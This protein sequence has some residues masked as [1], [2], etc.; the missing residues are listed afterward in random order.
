M[1]KEKRKLNLVKV[2]IAKLA[3]RESRAFQGGDT[4]GAEILPFAPAVTDW[5]CRGL[6]IDK[7]GDIIGH[8]SSWKCGG[9]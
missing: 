6:S 7:G 1:R 4:D 2:T 3:P 9:E 5:H 8:Y